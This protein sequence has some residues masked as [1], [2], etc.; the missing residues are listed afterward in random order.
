MPRACRSGRKKADRFGSAPYTTPKTGP[1]SPFHAEKAGIPR[2]D[3]G[4]TSGGLDS[5]APLSSHPCLPS[6]EDL[7]TAGSPRSTGVTPLHRYYG[8]ILHPLAFDRF[9][10]SPVIRPT[11][12]RPLPDGTRRASPV[13]QRAVVAVPPLPP[14]RSRPPLSASLQLTMLPSPRFH[15]LGLRYSL[16]TR[17]SV[18]S[19]SLQPGNSLTT[20]QVALSGGFRSSISLLPAPQA[21]GLLALAPAGLLPAERASLR[22][23]HGTAAGVPLSNDSRSGRREAPRLPPL[24]HREHTE[25]C[26]DRRS[27]D[28]P[29]EVQ[30]SINRYEKT[31]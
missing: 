4:S 21:T 29:T 7:P 2:I 18:R 20:P 25:R 26:S 15:G 10:G 23:S 3:Y 5:R 6:S 16:L 14:R 28:E 22:W 31:L 30:P 19:L 9:P 24:G 1:I 17:L 27:F 11:L 8:P 13:A 12:L